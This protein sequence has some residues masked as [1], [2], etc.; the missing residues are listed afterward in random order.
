MR[1]LG[2]SWTPICGPRWTI[3]CTKE[4]SFRGAYTLFFERDA[5]LGT[6]QQAAT[7]SCGLT[8]PP[9][10]DNEIEPLLEDLLWSLITRDISQFDSYLKSF[11]IDIKTPLGETVAGGG[12]VE[13]S[14]T[15]E[16]ERK[17][18][19]GEQKTMILGAQY[20]TSSTSSP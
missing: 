2:R 13:T 10:G 12:Q 1:F 14:R 4:R 20:R 5:C 7:M 8:N 11:H 6:K 16:K 19:G 15:I 17:K 3:A 18:G 9:A